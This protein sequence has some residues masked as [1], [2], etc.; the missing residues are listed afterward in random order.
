MLFLEV[1]IHLLS[2]FSLK[3]SSFR[4]KEFHY[5]LCE[6]LVFLENVF[7]DISHLFPI[8]HWWFTFS[9]VLISSQCST[10]RKTIQLIFIANRF[11]GFDISWT[12]TWSWLINISYKPYKQQFSFTKIIE[13]IEKTGSRKEEGFVELLCF[14]IF[15]QI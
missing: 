9:Y 5:Y 4:G 6:K 11:H 8:Q 13:K 10:N 1:Y 2:A 7:I 14:I 15:V 3:G 12:L